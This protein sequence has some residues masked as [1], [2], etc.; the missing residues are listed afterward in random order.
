MMAVLRF[1]ITQTRTPS[2]GLRVFES[3]LEPAFGLE[4]AVTLNSSKE[5]SLE[6]L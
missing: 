3:A 1:R 2:S 5:Y 4:L 6:E